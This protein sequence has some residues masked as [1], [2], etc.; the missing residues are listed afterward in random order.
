VQTTYRSAGGDTVSAGT[1]SV[2][3]TVRALGA[4]V[5]RMEDIPDALRLA[6]AEQWRRPVD[7][8][9]VAW[10]GVLE[11]VHL[12]AP[13]TDL[14]GP[15]AARLVMEDG[16]EE[17]W[18]PTRVSV[19][20]HADVEG[21]E[22]VEL[23]ATGSA[24]LPLGYHRL[25]V[26]VGSREGDALVI[27]APRRAPRPRHRSWGV[28]L[29]LYAL[30]SERSW[31]VGDLSDLRGLADWAA[32]L[33]AGF[34][35]TLPLL[36]AFLQG[37]T[38]EPSP[39]APASR[40]FWNELYVDPTGAAEFQGSREAQAL[41]A[42]PGF[43]R[44][45][46]RLRA[47]PTVPYVE[48]A[49][50]RRRVLELLANVA[51]DPSGRPGSALRA[52]IAAHPG[53]EDYARFRAATERHGG[54]W[55]T[56][57]AAERDGRLPRGG[58]NEQAYRFHLYGQWMAERQLAA[59]AAGSRSS[60]AGIYVDV[61]LGV[62]PAGYDVWRQREAFALDASVGAPPD[63]FFAGGQDWGFPPLH[64]QRIR[65]HGYRYVRDYLGTA[66]RHATAVRLDHVMGLHRQYWIPKGMPAER[67][68]YV[69]Y[70]LEELYAILN[71]EAHRAGSVVVGEDLGTVP[72]EVR[73]AM[74]RHGL[75]R[76]HVVELEARPAPAHALPRPSRNSMA[77]VNTH[78]LPMFAAFWRGQDIGLRRRRGWLTDEQ[79]RRAR[80]ERARVR[81]ALVAFLR[82]EGRILSPGE[83]S[84]RVALA[85]VLRHL[86][87]G[88][89]RMMVVNLEDLWGETRP[90]N[91]PG[92]ADELP[93]W[94]RRARPSLEAFRRMA[95]VVGTLEEVARLRRDRAGG[96]PSD[97]APPAR[98]R[99]RAP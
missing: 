2:L 96:E 48:A 88:P 42:S 5:E 99:G 94:R 66:C 15:Y 40:L 92:T 14:G 31:G 72:G 62:H 91:V 3:A 33:G 95:G 44:Q 97:A 29:P 16:G 27:A 90:Q 46:G 79:A 75:L 86:A 55:Q 11:S 6:T 36:A 78:D 19:G 81:E 12:R 82:T 93:N 47:S 98:K 54:W 68:V 21:T 61:P 34:V 73:T 65:E 38:V 24:R 56:W 76:S 83:P 85:G 53:V 50:L 4:P 22:H 13:A 10:D 8:A 67:G 43:R 28:F 63:P 58:G 70:P 30:H 25:H 7:A 84:A 45:L 35:A 51:F 77:S 20:R 26:T 1:E 52:F 49:A 23:V 89:A 59:L 9:M 32:E 60:G 74:G 18:H 57:P 69:R 41:V 64:P 39:Y 71:L 87:A 80:A 17:A 37:S